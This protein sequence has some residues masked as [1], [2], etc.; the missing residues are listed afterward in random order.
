MRTTTSTKMTLNTFHLAGAATAIDIEKQQQLGLFL[1]FLI[2]SS[3]S[4]LPDQS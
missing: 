4:L 1:L 2:S 3:S